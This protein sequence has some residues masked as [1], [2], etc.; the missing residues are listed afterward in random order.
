MEKTVKNKTEIKTSLASAVARKMELT[1]SRLA[2]K[3]IPFAERSPE[4]H[5]EMLR[6][7]MDASVQKD[8]VRVLQLAYALVRGRPYWWQERSVR[9]PAQAIVVAI[10]A[11]A[12]VTAEEAI[13]WL[14]APVSDDER[15]AF[16]L[17]LADARARE[18][19]RK[20]ARARARAA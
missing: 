10:A 12:D 13:A 8:A 19:D 4:Q 11:E 1:R 9:R 16:D 2:L 17:H 18:M 15:R 20:Q 7:G 5:R 14:Q 3:R 6:L